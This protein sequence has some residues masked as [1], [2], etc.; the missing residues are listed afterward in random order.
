MMTRPASEA[1][2]S[3]S[4]ASLAAL[5]RGK[6]CIAC[7]RRKVV[8][9]RLNLNQLEL[10]HP[11]TRGV[12]AFDQRVVSVFGVTGLKTVNIQIVRLS[13]EL[14]C[15]KKTSHVF[16]LECKNLNILTMLHPQSPFIIPIRHP[17]S[18]KGPL[19]RLIFKNFIFPHHH[20]HQVL[21][22]KT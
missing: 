9:S 6:A 8:R 19:L 16:K 5:Q 7:R 1:P 17:W 11:P 13:P 15:W 2:S 10:P 18:R 4:N 12:M 14:K 22:L 20:L 21:E 3:P